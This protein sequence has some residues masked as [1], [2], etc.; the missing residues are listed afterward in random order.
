[1]FFFFFASRRRHTRCYRDWSSD[2]CSSDLPRDPQLWT[3]HAGKQIVLSIAGRYEESRAESERALEIDPV[4]AGATAYSNIAATS[5]HLGDL[6]RARAA[7]AETL[8]VWPNM[9]EA[10]LRALFASIPEGPVEEFFHG[11]RLA[12]WTPDEERA[13]S[14]ATTTN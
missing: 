14:G 12:G 10:T 5:A 13:P 3:F 1:M 4:A 6:P 2:V 11:L 7:L 8:H 9:S